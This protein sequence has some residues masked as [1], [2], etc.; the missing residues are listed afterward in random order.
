MNNH[1]FS[2]EFAE[3]A[4]KGSPPVAVTAGMLAGMQMQDWVF[5]LT[6]VYLLLQIG[7]L[8]WKWIRDIRNNAGD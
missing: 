8:A 6:L 5:A 2:A 1:S 4:L 3:Q 7:Y